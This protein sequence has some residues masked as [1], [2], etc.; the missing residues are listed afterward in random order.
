MRLRGLRI[1]SLAADAVAAGEWGTVLSVHRRAVNLRLG[2]RALVAVLPEATPLHP[3]GVTAA[4]DPGRFN[5]GMAVWIGAGASPGGE[6]GLD[7][8]GAERVELRLTRRPPALPLDTSIALFPGK[9]GFPYP[10]PYA[11]SL[12]RAL[13]R[14]VAEGD[15]GALA[16]VV[17]LG[18]GLT[19][20]ADDV[21]VGVLA[22]LDLVREAAPEAV[23]RRRALVEALTPEVLRRTPDLSAQMIRAAAAGHYAEP[24][25]GVL[26]ALADPTHA[27]LLDALVTLSMMGHRSGLDTLSGVGAVVAGA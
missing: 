24:V 11:T 15:A 20:S 25:L 26:E 9:S 6:P 3:W 19:P 21:V 5:P 16:G 18:E 12:G 2:S 17:G 4:V 14:F 10:S 7:P 27:M 8:A 22:G 1:G 13:R 23:G